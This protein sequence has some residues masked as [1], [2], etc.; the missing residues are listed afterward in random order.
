MNYIYDI[1]LNYGNIPYDFFEWSTSDN[2]MH[3]RK[4]PII[5]VDANTLIDIRD[6]DVI[7]DNTFLDC[8]KRK[9]E[10]FN[11]RNI[12]VI[13]EA[14]LL[15]DGTNVLAIMLKNNHILKSKLLLEEEEEVL[16]ISEKIKEQAI[17]Y[18]KTKKIQI[19]QYKTRKQVEI[20][21]KIR[22]ELNKL[23]HDK[24]YET[25][26]FIHYECFNKK[27]ENKNIIREKLYSILDQS[28][29]HIIEKLKNILKL[30]EIKY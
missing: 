18:T 13:E 17:T 19:N 25:L 8:I 4:I 28:N 20:E 29:E 26:K 27:E 6:Y 2:I 12:K 16:I 22:K 7:F 1:L 14:C 23:F 15:S 11:N 9:T 24:N 3:I 5:K 10:V 30:L 21:Q